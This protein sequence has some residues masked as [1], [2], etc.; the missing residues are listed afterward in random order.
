MFAKMEFG[1]LADSTRGCGVVAMDLCVVCVTGLLCDRS[2]VS[3]V[4]C[5]VLFRRMS[6]DVR[7]ILHFPPIPHKK[8]PRHLEVLV[9]DDMR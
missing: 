8:K 2:P 6:K 7:Q 3:Q 1:S 9:I 5:V 4:F